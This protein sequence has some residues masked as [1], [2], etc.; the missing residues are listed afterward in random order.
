MTPWWNW[1]GKIEWSVPRAQK[2]R[3]GI[4]DPE[5]RQREVRRILKGL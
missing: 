3:A 2:E 4:T 1:E 5:K